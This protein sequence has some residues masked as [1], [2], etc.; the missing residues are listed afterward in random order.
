MSNTKL[1]IHQ[2]DSLCE[3]DESVADQ[4]FDVRYGNTDIGG[5]Y[6]TFE[7]N[8]QGTSITLFF[9]SQGRFT[10]QQEFDMFAT[11]LIDE[12][13]RNSILALSH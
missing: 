12:L 3:V 5:D 8:F 13:K 11:E 1:S 4:W 7:I 2:R 6:M 10:V 9:G